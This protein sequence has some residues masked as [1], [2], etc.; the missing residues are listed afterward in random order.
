MQITN[1]P[2][3]G[4]G[5][6]TPNEMP[7][8]Y[9]LNTV[10]GTPPLT[11]NGTKAALPQSITV[12]GNMDNMLN[13][14]GN[15]VENGNFEI[16][17]TIQKNSDIRAFSLYSTV[18]LYKIGAVA[19]SL[20]V[21]PETKTA[22]LYRECGM[23]QFD[24]SEGWTLQTGIGNN[25]YT[26][27]LDNAAYSNYNTNTSVTNLLPTAERFAVEAATRGYHINTVSILSIYTDNSSLSDFKAWLAAQAAAGTPL[28]I[29]YRLKSA[30]TTDV[31]DIQDWTAIPELYSSKNDISVLTEVPPSLIEL[32]CYQR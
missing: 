8:K 4:F 10:S 2:V 5:Y 31:S 26:I 18:Q 24:G 12:Y 29:I 1:K 19:D 28:T 21:E 23:A 30:V 16:P 7:Q 17:V 3:T 20:A 22:V 6:L 13:G 14:V 15:A 11:V 9:I 32:N 27:K 25:V